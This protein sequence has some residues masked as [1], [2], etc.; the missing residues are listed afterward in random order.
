MNFE[1][2]KAHPFTTIGGLLIGVGQYLVQNGATAPNDLKSALSLLA[3]AAI[4]IAMGM[5]KDPQ[6]LQALLAAAA[7]AN[8]APALVAALCASLLLSACTAKKPLTLEQQQAV[9]AASKGVALGG[10]ILL[11]VSMQPDEVAKLNLSLNAF[12]GVLQTRTNPADIKEAIA[13]L[14]PDMVIFAASVTQLIDAATAQIPSSVR[15]SIWYEVAQNVVQG[16]AEA[17]PT[18]AMAVDLPAHIVALVDSLTRRCALPARTPAQERT[19]TQCLNSTPQEQ[20]G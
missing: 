16:C 8:K 10:C 9:T 13:L 19:Q 5:I 4:T 12:A 14:D 7:K 11:K 20:I 17:P 3:G 1:N 6:F 15:N 2:F 18:A